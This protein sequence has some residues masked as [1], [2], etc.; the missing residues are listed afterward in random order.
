[1][2]KYLICLT[3]L[4]LAV[5]FSFT[6]FSKDSKI[7]Y[8]DVIK[9][10]NE[11]EKTKNYEK[12]LDRKKKEV[13][14]ELSEKREIIEKMSS[15]LSLLKDEEREK[16]QEKIREKVREY[17]EIGRGAELDMKKIVI[18]Q[19][20]EMKEDMDKIIEK[21]AKKNGFNLI[22]DGNSVLYGNK[23]MDVTS[24]ILKISNKQYRKKK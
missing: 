20:T 24:D 2:K 16:E 6:C 13:E 17:Q 19:M 5:S 18:E 8:V 3:V 22:V 12:D 4:V 23:A 10:F 14:E 9:V 11:Y 21:Y 7:G 15:K 1:M